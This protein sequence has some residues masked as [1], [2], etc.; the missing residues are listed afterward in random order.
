MKLPALAS[1]LLLLSPAIAAQDVVAE[2]T[3]QS[4]LP[5]DPVRASMEVPRLALGFTVDPAS[6]SL[7]GTADYT[8][9][10]DTPQDRLAFDLDP[11]FA[12]SGISVDG[13][14]LAPAAWSNPAG[15]LTITLPRAL[16]AGSRAQI[17]IAW[18]GAP[19]VA[20]R[21]PWDGG[22]T[23]ARTPDG[24]PWVASAIQGEGCDMFWPCLDHPTKRIGLLDLSV[25]VPDGLVAA[26]N[27]VLIGEDH[28]GGWATWHWRARQPNNYGVTLQIGPYRLAE[29]QYRSAYGNTIPVQYWHLPG[30]R[31]ED[32]Q[33]LL[34]GM[35]D[36]LAF[37]E[38]VVGP[39]PW[40]DEKV[41]LAETPHLGMEH[42]T[43]NAYGNG[44]KRAPEGYDWLAQH[45]FGHEWFANQMTNA[46][47]G[48]MWLHEGLDTYMQP[49]YL[50]WKNG[51]MAYDV[52]LWDHRKR[53]L[54]RVPLAAGDPAA[55]GDYLDAESGWGN[56][57]YYKGSWV[58]HTLRLLIG[59]TAFRESLRRLVYGRPDPA[60]GNFA[61][62]RRTTA[63][64]ATIVSEVTGRPMDW[65]FDAY[66]RQ[67]ALPRLL[68][69]RQGSRLRLRWE[70]ASAL[71]FTMPVEVQVGDRVLVAPMADG[72]G[73]LD[74]G[75]A[76]ARHVIDPE[77]KILRDDPAITAW[78]AQERAAEAH[79]KD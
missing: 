10:V 2:R 19:H 75:S 74:L 42:Q 8:V 35:Q 16:A 27:G 26:G 55:T 73:M 9:T 66:V 50:L 14:A 13:Q 46:T 11:R 28:A 41:G 31:P 39:Y 30:D 72:T 59:D 37:F 60:P 18:H 3:A 48:E 57:I 5:L 44:Y 70:T 32:V 64:F 79:A 6:R 38:D 40:G 52:A 45:E 58:T 77:A 65:F 51:R 49:L 67:A 47:E 62:V 12:I 69:E 68:E 54:S 7:A 15:L 1:A 53:V 23:W 71:P 78:Q 24:Q 17:R 22:F 61:P 4:G 63:D 25:T 56:D 34:A 21:A 20:K 76:D 33:Y 29:A 43:I 36:Y